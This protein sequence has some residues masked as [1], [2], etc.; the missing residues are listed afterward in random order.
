MEMLSAIL[1]FFTAGLIGTVFARF[2]GMNMSMCVLLILLYRG[3]RPVEAVVAML[4]FNVFTYF[5]V[6]SQIHIMRLKDFVIFPGVRI[7]I[8]VLLTVALAALNPFFGIIFFVI[9]FLLEIFVKMYKEMDVK[10]RPSK[11]KLIQMCIAAGIL[12]SVGAVVAAFIPDQY[13]Y[14]LVSIAILGFAALMWSAG[15]RRKWGHIWDKILYGTVLVTGLTGIDA[16]DWLVPMRRS[17]ESNLSRCYPIVIN[18][19]MIIGLIVLYALYHYF[20]LGALFTTIGAAVGIRLFGLYEHSHKSGFSYVTL[21]LTVL[22]VLIF[23]L[24][25]PEATGFPVIPMA[26]QGTSFFNF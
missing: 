14:L 6:Y 3:A 5:T 8:P 10:V 2:T 21:G 24:V 7:A 13:Y 17:N 4:I 12:L 1:P 22:V 25:Q 9:V 19:A 20:S 11:Q 16:T 15:D 26:D 18:A 23:M